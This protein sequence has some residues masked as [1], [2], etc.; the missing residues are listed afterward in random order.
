[1]SKTSPFR[2]IPPPPP[3]IA[4]DRFGNLL[5]PGHLVMYRPELDTIFE[6]VEVA[7]EIHP[8]A[9]KGTMRVI[10]AAQFPIGVPYATP[11]NRLVICGKSHARVQAEQMTAQNGAGL[12]PPPAVAEALAQAGPKLVL[13]DPVEEVPAEGAGVPSG[14]CPA[15]G[16]EGPVGFPCTDCGDAHY[17]EV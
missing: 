1:M 6:V 5:E 12:A 4:L 11:I 15:C 7:P 8:S 14:A 10:L 3:A 17:A 16:H 13:T 9:P 2:S